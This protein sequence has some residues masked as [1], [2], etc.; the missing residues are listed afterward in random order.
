MHQA[1]LNNGPQM[2]FKA[3][4]LDIPCDARA[5]L[6]FKEVAGKHRS[7]NRSVN[8]QVGNMDFPFDS[9]V[10]AHHKRTATIARRTDIPFDFPI[11]PQATDKSHIAFDLGPSADQAVN[12]ALWFAGFIFFRNMVCLR[13]S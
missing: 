11:N 9:G 5:R 12:P 3:A 10:L 13:F 2:H 8:N 6:K 7:N 1:A 4:V